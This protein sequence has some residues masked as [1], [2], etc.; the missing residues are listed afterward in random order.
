MGDLFGGTTKTT[1]E[2]NPWAPQG[3]AL[4]GIF[5]AAG[6]AYDSKAGTPWYQGDLYA[7]MDPATAN[8]IHGVL[9][10]TGNT[11]ANSAGAITNAGQA[12]MNPNAVTSANDRYS[13]AA[14]ADPTQGN[15]A[16]A[17]AYANNP[18]IDGMVDAASRDVNRNLFE[19]ELPGLNQAATGSGNVN[20]S[21][22]GVAEG[23]MRRGAADRVGDISS[24]IRGDAYNRGLSLAEGARDTNLNAMGNAAGLYGQQ[25]GQGIGALTSGNNL[26]MSNFGSAI[27]SSQL[28]QKD[29]QGQ[30]DAAMTAWQANDNRD[31]DL[32]SK[33]YGIVG[34]NN[35]GGTSTTTQKQSGNILGTLAGLA[36]TAAGFGAFGGAGGIGKMLGGGG[37]GG[38]FP[39]IPGLSNVPS[40]ANPMSSSQIGSALNWVQPIRL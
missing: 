6:K 5:S 40:I 24:S 26:A 12:L 39:S 15:I 37:G 8:A 31:M 13:A 21:R 7:S 29:R 28:F 32:L 34:A 17:T 4:K 18:A 10:Y 36:S 33:Y 25:L 11:G 2:T 19:N 35:W 30:D 22:A 14:G 23:I 20:S 27:D 1:Q 38:S 3:D 9:D 16:A